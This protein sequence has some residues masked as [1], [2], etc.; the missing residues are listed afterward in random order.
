[1][2]TATLYAL[3]PV[4]LFWA[5]MQLGAGRGAAFL[6]ALG[7]SL[8]SPSCWLAWQARVQSGGW[9]GAHRLFAMVRYGEGPHIASLLLL[10]LAIGL[11][12]RAIAT[13]KPYHFV[14]A[15]LAMAATVLCNWIGAVALAMAMAAYLLAGF[16]K[17]WKAAWLRSALVGIYAYALAMSG[18]LLRP[19][20]PFGP[21]RRGWWAS[22]RPLGRSG[23]WPPR[24]RCW[25]GF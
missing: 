13:R 25:P 18:R 3:G 4:A 16:W 10:P 22:N 24:C 9:F 14:L 12:H 23:C 21:V 2:V 17:L 8:L 1:M 6:A 5:A 20:P 19:W 11:I 15:A 7:Y